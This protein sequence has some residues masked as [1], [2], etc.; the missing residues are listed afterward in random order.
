MS[1]CAQPALGARESL[2]AEFAGWIRSGASYRVW[3]AP[4]LPDTLPIGGQAELEGK[5]DTVRIE[6]RILRN[7]SR[8]QRAERELW[9]RARGRGN[10]GGHK[11]VRQIELERQRMGREL[12]TGVGQ[13]L[14]AIGLQL[15]V[16][17]AQMPGPAGAIQRAL[18]AI[19]RLAA[20]RSTRRL[21]PFASG[22][23]AAPHAGDGPAPIVGGHRHSTAVPGPVGCSKRGA[24]S[25]R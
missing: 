20:G 22:G 13:M 11:A 16:V 3:P 17:A 18:D 14:A 23:V 19:G 25:S 21:A 9:A 24:A 5:P 15:E 8:L 6:D 12:H 10:G 2:A 1:A 7:Y 4:A